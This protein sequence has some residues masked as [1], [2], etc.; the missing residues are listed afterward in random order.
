MSGDVAD[1]TDARS[2]F[3]QVESGK[4]F[5]SGHKWLGDTASMWCLFLLSI[6]DPKADSWTLRF[7]SG[8]TRA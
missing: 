6:S 3:S 5:S 1:S 2:T 8:D 7:F 4:A